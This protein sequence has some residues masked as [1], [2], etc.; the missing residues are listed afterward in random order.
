MKRILT[1]FIIIIS[2]VAGYVVYLK[3]EANM[4]KTDPL[5][6]IL[7]GPPGAG[8][9]THAIE[10]C[11]KLHI[12]HISTG[13]LFREN[14]QNNTDLGKKAKNYMD[15]GKLAPDNLVNDMLFDRLNK[16]DCNKGYILD[17]FPRNLSQANSLDDYLKS[18]SIVP[19][20]LN[21]VVGDDVIIER[22]INRLTCKKCKAPYHKIFMKPKK[23]DICDRCGGDLIHRD[24]DSKEVVMER[25][26]VYYNQ[27]K[28]LLSHYSQNKNSFFEIDGN[29]NKNQ[30]LNNLIDTI[31]NIKR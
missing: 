12:P 18:K 23:E 11:K 30:I 22:I 24:D 6:I 13:D 10:L 29:R 15:Q 27:T 20:T 19:L 25:L 17:G 28:P 5:V 1:I 31:D 8:K 9:G 26:E 3:S 14:L 2:I 21:L 4:K 16:Q 7:I